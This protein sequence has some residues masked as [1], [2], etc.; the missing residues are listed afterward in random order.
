MAK[1]ELDRTNFAPGMARDDRPRF[2]IRQTM[3][4]RAAYRRGVGGLDSFAHDP[5]IAFIRILESTGFG[6]AVVFW[7]GKTYEQ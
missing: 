3:D 6:P 4:G 5:E 2:Y 1:R 7:E